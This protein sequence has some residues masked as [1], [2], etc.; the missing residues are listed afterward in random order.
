MTEA[1]H[2]PGAWIYVSGT[3][4]CEK[5]LGADGKVVADTWWCRDSEESE[6]NARLIAS[7]PELLE[8]LKTLDKR[9][10]EC[11]AIDSISARDAYDSFYQEVVSEVIKKATGQT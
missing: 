10:K 6:A 1:K 2:T 4:T 8:A 9:F 11:A 7:A 3:T 5:V